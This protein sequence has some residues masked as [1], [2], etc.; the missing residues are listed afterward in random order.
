MKKLFAAILIAS[1]AASCTYNISMAHTSGQASDVIDD[2]LTPQNT[3]SPNLEV[4]LIGK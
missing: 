1:I 2:T 4:P 3:I